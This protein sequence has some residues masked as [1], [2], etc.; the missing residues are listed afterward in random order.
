MT[1]FRVVAG[2][3]GVF[4]ALFMI[5]LVWDRAEEEDYPEG[6]Q[7]TAPAKTLILPEG[8]PKPIAP[9]S[10][11]IRAGDFVFVAGQIGIDP[12]T[13]AMVQGGIVPETRQVLANLRTLLNAAGLDFDDAVRATVY[14]ADLDDYGTFNEEYGAVIGE[15]PP[16]RVAIQVARLPLDARVEVSMIAYG[17]TD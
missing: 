4:I 14:L 13:N 6:R 10:P 5:S 15:V 17:P 16:S 9:Y 11:A 3:L 2:L 7:A 8:A 12:E 1:P